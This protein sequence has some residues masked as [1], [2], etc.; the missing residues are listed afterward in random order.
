MTKSELI[1]RLCAEQTHLSAKEIEDA[2]KDIIEHMATSLEQ[3]DRIEIR[4]FGSFSL[5][6]REPRTGRNPKTGEKVELD[7]K[8]VPHFKP[9]K[10]LRERVNSTI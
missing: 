2:V 5:H 8:Y 6:Y 7:G 1:E 9:G 10:E 3:G 4:G